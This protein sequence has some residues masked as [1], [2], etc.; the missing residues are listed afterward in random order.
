M[1][2]LLGFAVAAM[3]VLPHAASAQGLSA[4]MKGR[5]PLTTVG[6][7]QAQAGT[8]PLQSGR[9]AFVKGSAR[10]ASG[11]SGAYA[12]PEICTNCDD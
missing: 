7:M 11:T 10:G 6:T 8:V 12:S 3:V 1:K 5:D 9:S 4:S 2:D